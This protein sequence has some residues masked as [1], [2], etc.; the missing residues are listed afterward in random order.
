MASISL[1]EV[2]DA[3]SEEDEVRIFGVLSSSP[4]YPSP[5]IHIHVK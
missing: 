2:A 5:A 4:S 1:V 3:L